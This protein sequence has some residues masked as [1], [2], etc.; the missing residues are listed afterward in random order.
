MTNYSLVENSLDNSFQIV[1]N[2]AF[3][4][5]YIQSCNFILFDS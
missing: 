5:L 2:I 3:L 1:P 4:F